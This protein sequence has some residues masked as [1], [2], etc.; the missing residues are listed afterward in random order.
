MLEYDPAS[1][2][3]PEATSAK[4]VLS[5]FNS[6]FKTQIIYVTALFGSYLGTFAFVL[7]GIVSLVGKIRRGTLVKKHTGVDAYSQISW[8]E[9]EQLVGEVYRRQ[10]F[11]VTELGGDEPDGGIDM[12]VKKDDAT[13]LVQ[14]KHWK[15]YLV[16]VKVVREMLGLVTA[17]RATGAI[18]LTSGN[19]TADALTFARNT[20]ITLIAGKELSHMISTIK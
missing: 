17:H 10:G 5:G 3:M 4:A 18:I 12:I 8:K 20:G 14:C 19:F 6:G 1:I 15:A 11:A 7:G 2:T 13:Y 16:G 9:F